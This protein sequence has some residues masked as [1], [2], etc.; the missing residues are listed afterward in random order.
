MDDEDVER[1]AVNRRLVRERVMQGLYAYEI[2]HLVGGESVDFLADHLVYP[3]FIQHTELLDFAQTL[4]RRTFNSSTDCDE[5]IMS[6]SENWDFHRI[7]PVDKVLLRMGITEL[8]HFPE[9]P[10]KVTI[11]EVIE[12]AKRYS[13]DKSSIFINGLLDAAL[14]KLKKD[15]RLTKSGRGL[16]GEAGEE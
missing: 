13:T 14:S 16:I 4:M 12:I 2:G 1:P 3:E 9:I 7:A 5:I 10:T 11:N 6:L 15:G 8:I